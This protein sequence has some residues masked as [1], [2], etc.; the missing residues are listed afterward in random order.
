MV[1]AI[2]HLTKLSK[3]KIDFRAI[4]RLNGSISPFIKNL[5]FKLTKDQGE[6]NIRYKKRFIPPTGASRS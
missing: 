6:G 2:N 5:P 1:E 3:K 4:K